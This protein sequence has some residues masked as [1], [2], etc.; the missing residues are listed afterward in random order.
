M[1]FLTISGFKSLNNRDII[2]LRIFSQRDLHFKNQF[3]K[4]RLLLIMHI[5][6][7]FLLSETFH[8]LEVKMDQNKFIY[9]PYS[10]ELIFL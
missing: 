5:I 2:C 10:I 8:L 4:S 6:Y 9:F 7:Y 1:F 3:T